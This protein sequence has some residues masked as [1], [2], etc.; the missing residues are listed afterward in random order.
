MKNR[1]RSYE[2]L[3]RLILCIKLNYLHYDKQ[4]VGV[5]G[6]EPMR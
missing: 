1:A 6:F 3:A 5:M 4:F 2:K